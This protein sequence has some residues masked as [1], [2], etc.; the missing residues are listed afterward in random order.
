MDCI[1]TAK[2]NPT[3]AAK[4]GTNTIQIITTTVGTM[5]AL[6][7]LPARHGRLRCS[8]LRTISQTCRHLFC[9]NF[10][11]ALFGEAIF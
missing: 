4:Q 2:E 11:V 5:L 10:S 8:L 9:D 1:V 3:G 6:D 7:S